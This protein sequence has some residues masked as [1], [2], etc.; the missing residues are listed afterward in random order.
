MKH[1]K[2]FTQLSES[3]NPFGINHI[4]KVKKMMR[5]ASPIERKI[6]V[7]YQYFSD[8]Y[9]ARYQFGGPGDYRELKSGA[10]SLKSELEKLGYTVELDKQ[11]GLRL[12]IKDI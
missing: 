3:F 4:K 2:N 10:E 7:M 12:D 9:L 8:R 11:Y 1:L 6:G 5:D